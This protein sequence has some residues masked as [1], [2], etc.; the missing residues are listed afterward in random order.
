MT[1]VKICGV[2]QPEHALAAAEAGADFI[3]LNFYE[4]SPRFVNK[5][6][7]KEIV[8]EVWFGQTIQ[9]TSELSLERR[10]TD[11]YDRIRLAAKVVERFLTKK[12]PL[13]V[14]I[15]VDA[16]PARINRIADEVG[17]DMV[18]LSGSELP[19]LPPK[20]NRPAI[21]VLK[22]R[23]EQSAEEIAGVIRHGT[24]ALHMLET[25]VEGVRGGSGRTFD[26]SLAKQVG[27]HVPVMISGGLRPNNVAEA[28]DTAQ[29]WGVDVAS[30][31]ETDGVKDVQKIRDFIENAKRASQN[32]RI[33]LK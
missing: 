23:P 25:H 31:V 13:F 16:V 29:P 18:Q 27:E 2:T 6:Q 12:R 9:D 30:G 15:F 20:L 26:W 10:P 28:V 33:P 7:A 3:G 1:Y 5:E 4:E 14:G 11:G 17:L 24:A 8:Q 22:V 32:L 21:K 19:N